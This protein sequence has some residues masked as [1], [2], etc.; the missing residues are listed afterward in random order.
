MDH[1]LDVSVA[2]ARFRSDLRRGDQATGE[3]DG[4]STLTSEA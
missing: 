3:T 1:P 2:P 4:T